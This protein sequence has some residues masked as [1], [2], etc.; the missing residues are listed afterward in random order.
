MSTTTLRKRST[1]PPAADTSTATFADAIVPVSADEEINEIDAAVAELSEAETADLILMH[2]INARR[3]IEDEKRWIVNYL[4][5]D[6]RGQI[7]YP[8]TDRACMF[9]ARGA[10]MQSIY[11]YQGSTGWHDETF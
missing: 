5:K 2:L 7:C 6:E 9:C 3:L 1:Q 10:V 11:D 8:G 4:A